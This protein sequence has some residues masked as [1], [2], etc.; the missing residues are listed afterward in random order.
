MFTVDAGLVLSS[1]K[2]DYETSRSS[3]AFTSTATDT[4]YV[5]E[6]VTVNLKPVYGF[7]PRHFLN[8]NGVKVGP[9]V[10]IYHMEQTNGG[11]IGLAF[12][13]LPKILVM[14]LILLSPRRFRSS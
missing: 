9:E 13:T 4:A 6:R 5:V 10:R 3:V 1:G 7:D 11:G 8:M 12:S 14:M 2:L